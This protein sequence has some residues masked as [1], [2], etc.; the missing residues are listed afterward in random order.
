MVPRLK[1]LCMLLVRRIFCHEFRFCTDELVDYWTEDV[2][3]MILLLEEKTGC[4]DYWLCAMVP[5]CYTAR[6]LDYFQKRFWVGDILK[7]GAR[8]GNME[9]IEF[10]VAKG[11]NEFESAMKHA[12]E[13]GHLGV[14]DFFV[15][16]GA[17]N[18]HTWNRILENASENGHFEVVRRAITEGATRF[19]DV[20]YNGA[21]LGREDIIQLAISHGA[22]E[23]NQAM[24][25]SIYGAHNDWVMFFI[26]KGADDWDQGLLNSISCRNLE[27]FDLMIE[28]GADAKLP[29]YLER[30]L[31]IVGEGNHW[32]VDVEMARRLLDKGA[33]PNLH[34]DKMPSAL[35]RDCRDG[36]IEFTRLLLEH[37]MKPVDEFLLTCAI[38]QNDRLRDLLVEFGASIENVLEYI[39][40]KGWKDNRVGQRVRKF[41][42][43]EE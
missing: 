11:A 9:L 37:G 7:G 20:L 27:M 33:D 23:W 2:L 39:S 6:L 34:R 41:L 31:R 1:V 12:A 4:K 3:D 19:E 29:K 26:E 36:A 13:G 35:A 18:P 40:K 5:L 38:C 10:A 17:G 30:L 15:E 43:K 16:K 42:L 14:I 28:K 21:Y 24:F 32:D 25:G 8:G 22:N